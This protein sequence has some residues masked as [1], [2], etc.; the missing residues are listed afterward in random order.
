MMQCNSSINKNK[1]Y[2]HTH[3]PEVADIFRALP[4]VSEVDLGKQCESQEE[5]PEEAQGVE[6]LVV[7]HLLI[8][9]VFPNGSLMILP[10]VA[11][12][13]HVPTQVGTYYRCNH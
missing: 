11:Y 3:L 10:A 12:C 9:V 1:K 8:Y 2:T 13:Q 5:R 7:R 6:Y 4:F